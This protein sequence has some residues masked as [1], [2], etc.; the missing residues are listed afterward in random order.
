MVSSD[1]V[2]ISPARK[3]TSVSRGLNCPDRIALGNLCRLPLQRLVHDS[4]NPPHWARTGLSVFSIDFPR[5][6][7][8]KHDPRA[9][10]V[11]ACSQNTLGGIQLAVHMQAVGRATEGTSSFPG[12]SVDHLPGRIDL[13]Q[14]DEQESTELDRP[15]C[16]WRGVVGELQMTDQQAPV[17]IGD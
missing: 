12:S 5:Q 3:L 2:Q 6:Y 9:T 8:P 1:D 7:F 14:A 16:G 17:A 13:D 15:E 10:R 4:S 11:L